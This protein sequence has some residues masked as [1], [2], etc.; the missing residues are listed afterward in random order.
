MDEPHLRRTRTKIHPAHECDPAAHSRRVFL[1]KLS[2]LLNAAVGA[3]LAVPLV[4]YLLGP[5]AEKILREGAWIALGPLTDFPMR[6][7]PPRQLPQSR[8][9]ALRWR[10]RQYRLLGAPHRRAIISGLRHQLRASR[11]PR[12]LVRAI[13]TLPL[14]LPRRRVLRRWLPASGPPERGLFEYRY[15][16]VTDTS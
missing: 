16:I 14:P 11:M 7:N 3:I 9:P 12:P 5:A 15:Q 1:F 2:L 6:R 4:G 8:R 10:H 13:Q